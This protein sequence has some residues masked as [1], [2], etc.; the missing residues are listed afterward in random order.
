MPEPGVIAVSY[1]YP[2]VVG[3]AEIHTQRMCAGLRRL[4]MPALVITTH[5]QGMPSGAEWD[6]EF[7]TPVHAC[8]CSGSERQRSLALSFYVLRHL[9]FLKGPYQILHWTMPGLQALVGIPVAWALGMV[10]VMMFPGSGEARSLQRSSRGRWLLGI[11]RKKADAIIILNP[12]MRKEVES[13]G[14]SP[15]RT[16]WFPCEVEATAVLTT[17]Q[18]RVLRQEYGLPPEACIIVSSGRFV[19]AKRLHDLVRAFA[20]ASRSAPG[21][22]LALAGDGPLRQELEELVVSLGIKNRVYFFGMLSPG[23]TQTLLKCADVFALVSGNEGFPC[24]LVEAMAAGLPCVVTDISGLTQLVADGVHGI[25][26]PV[27]KVDAIASALLQLWTD[28]D[29]RQVLGGEARGRVIPQH[30]LDAVAARS[31]ELYKGLVA[32]KARWR[33]RSPHNP[34]WVKSGPPFFN[35]QSFD[36]LS[37]VFVLVLQL[38]HHARISERSSVA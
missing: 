37:R 30:S 15:D 11:L 5:C 29:R 2:P 20:I 25:V 19:E 8:T 9:L 13:L 22:V 7:G 16:H 35:P 18:R 33:W 27:G 14:F 17:A 10:N 12:E 4:G 21:A 23:R 26:V 24:S 34:L 3:G 38:R 32:G 28:P 31:H 36:L 1:V 6:D